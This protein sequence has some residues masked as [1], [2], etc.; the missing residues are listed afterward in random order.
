MKVWKHTSYLCRSFLSPWKDENGK[1]QFEGRF[2]QGVVSLNLPQIGIVAK[3]NEKKFWKSLDD[4]LEIC[5][6]ALMCRH[7]ALKKAKS[8]NS[9]I[10]WRHG[11]IS[12]LE[13]NKSIESLLVGGYSTISL[14]YIG[15]YEM[16]LLVT[17]ESHT[18]EK[19]QEFALRVLNYLNDTVEKWKKDTGIGFGLYGTPAESLCYRFARLDKENYG[20]IEN[21]TDKGYY[22]NSYHVD[23]REDIDVFSKFAFE[24]QFQ[25]I[26]LGGCISYVEIPNMRHN[27]EAIEEIVRYI[28]DNIMYAEFNTKS[29]YCSSCGFDG[30]ISVNDNIEWECPQCH[31][32]DKQKLSV[33]RRT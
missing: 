8:D 29:D 15:V 18:T 31:E 19:G 14:G 32:K 21:V 24:S 17:G 4:R 12:R 6:K 9:P 7:N 3:G 30:E 22:T 5:Y 27:L 2:N 13:K 16:T 20:D 23:V 10:H 1:Y 26:S 33:C 28:Y 11:A 25:S